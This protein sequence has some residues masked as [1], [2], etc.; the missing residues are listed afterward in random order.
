MQIFSQELDIDSKLGKKKRLLNNAFK[1]PVCY[2]SDCARVCVRRLSF[3]LKRCVSSLRSV[4][5]QLM[6]RDGAY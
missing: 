6:I 1:D 5:T 4:W 3:K 2:L